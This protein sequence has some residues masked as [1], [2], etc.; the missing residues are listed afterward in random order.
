MALPSCRSSR[1]AIEI[2]E[3]SEQQHSVAAP[4]KQVAN[5]LERRFEAMTEAYQPWTDLTVPVKVSVAKPKNISL[6]G[7]MTMVYGKALSISMKMLFIEAASLY[8]DNDSVIIV[9]KPMGVYYAE[10]I[11]RFTAA[12]GL[13]LSD[14]QSMML[15]QAFVPGKGTARKSDASDFTFTAN[16]AIDVPGIAAWTISPRKMPPSVEWY[17]TA[18]APA[19]ESVTTPPQIFAVDIEA[20]SNTVECTFAQ[21]EMSKAGVIAAK[22]QLVGK[23][24]KRD[25]DLTVAMTPSRATWN[26]GARVSRPSIPRGARKVSTEQVLKLLNN[27]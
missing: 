9:S 7:T 3:Y 14:L 24:K 23:V 8:A 5:T 22:M 2:Q 21:S 13:G 26:S 10:S 19:D 20:G 25:I 18:L 12:T 27:M 1:K 17:Y 16:T 4:V 15:G 6:S 11:G